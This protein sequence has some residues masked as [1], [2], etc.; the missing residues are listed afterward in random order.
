MEITMTNVN[1][2]RDE[3]ASVF[4]SEKVNTDIEVITKKDGSRDLKVIW[5]NNEN[6]KALT[7]QK[8]SEVVSE[9]YYQAFQ[10]K[11]YPEYVLNS[12]VGLSE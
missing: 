2:M 12:A 7:D 1:E 11:D 9:A 8:R 4:L 10:C 3:L 5:R 6:W